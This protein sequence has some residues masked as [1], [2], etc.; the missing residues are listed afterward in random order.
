MKNLNRVHL[1]GLRA[2]EAVG[3]LGAL[4]AAAGE[5]GVTAGAVSQQIIRVEEQLGQAI[6]ERTPRGLRPTAFGGP[7][8]ARLTSAFG[9]L[10][11]A[12]ATVERRDEGILTIS[13]APVF[14]SRWLIH[15]LDRFSA[16]HPQISL[17]IEATTTL[18]DLARSDVDLGIRVGPGGWPDAAAEFLMPQIVFPVC[19]PALAE[20]IK[21]PEDL[22]AEP[23]VVDG[24]D[25]FTWD[26]WLKAAG[27]SMPPPKIRHVFS[28][29]SLCLDAALAGQGVLLAFPVLASW[30]LKEGRLVAPVPIGVETGMGYY[31]V[32]APGRP[33]PRK[34]AVFKQWL[35]QAMAE[36]VAASPAV[37]IIP[38]RRAAPPSSP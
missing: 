14:A 35:R 32:T 33:E 9:Q 25:A 8:L 13:V 7:F 2:L 6:F 24:H 3:R 18:V 11:E 20:R 30:A 17:R 4:Q 21:T 15:R 1:N 36:D 16:A 34:V 19:A 26:H 38:A 12:V 22:S 27:F 28:D 37:R 10:S 31:F 29:A 5:L 23:A